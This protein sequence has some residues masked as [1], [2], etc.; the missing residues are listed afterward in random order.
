[1]PFKSVL[2]FDPQA[3]S[4]RQT[5][6]DCTSHGTRNAINTSR[7]VEIDVKGEL[8]GYEARIA[9]EPI[10]G[11]RGHSGQGMSPALASQFCHD[12][13]C[14]VRKNYGFVDLT[15]YNSKI[16]EAWG[17]RGVPAEVREECK[18]HPARYIARIT[19]M[20]ELRDAC[21]NGYGMHVGSN[22]GFSNKRDA[23]GIAAPSGNWSHDMAILA[24]DDTRE[25]ANEILVGIF[26]SW[27]PWNSGG[28]A[29]G[30][31]LVPGAF[32]VLGSVFEKYMLRPGEVW[33]VGNFQGFPPQRLPNYG[34]GSFLG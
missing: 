15:K 7:S 30:R 26:N 24:V 16:G 17:G 28:W 6:G 22:Q 27:G 5:T 9:T 18:K 31:E 12:F 14:M 20:E 29:P 32:W 25:I 4:E 21:A 19:S 2:K 13:G 1:M 10:Y 3:F 8:E 23:N 34:A 11:A 33:A